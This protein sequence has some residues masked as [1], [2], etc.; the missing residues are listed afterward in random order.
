MG[1]SNLAAWQLMKALGIAD[2]T[3]LPRF[4]SQQIYYSPQERSVEYELVPLALDQGLGTL[5]WSPLAGGLSSGKYRR[6]QQGPE[7]SPRLTDWDEP[8][9]YDEEVCTTRSTCWSRS[10]RATGCPPPRWRR[11]GCCAVRRSAR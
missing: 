6:G 7:G 5:V 4:V 9:V 3:S 10:P 1:A 8:P 11:P 2:R